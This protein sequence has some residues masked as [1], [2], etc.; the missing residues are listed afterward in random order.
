MFVTEINPLVLTGNR[1]SLGWTA[2][3][4]GAGMIRGNSA[5]KQ[6]AQNQFRDTTALLFAKWA[7]SWVLGGVDWQTFI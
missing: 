6:D 5:T 3:A 7:Y 2:W 1:V 4:E